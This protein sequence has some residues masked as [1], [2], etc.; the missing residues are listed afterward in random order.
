MSARP[1]LTEEVRHGQLLAS[2]AADEI[3]RLLGCSAPVSFQAGETLMAQGDEGSDMWLLLDGAAEVR[4]D[5]KTLA[6]HKAGQVIGEMS[7]LDPA[8]RA[9]TVV[10]TAKGQAFRLQRDAFLQLLD[11]RD[12]VAIKTLR[13]LTAIAC[14]R[15]GHMNALV[16]EEIMGPQEKGVLKRL[17]RKVTGR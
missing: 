13:A 16:Q 3:Q 4:R 10:A 17:W 5:G 12:D 2:L 6:L 1:T 9:A 14:Q 11:E 8:P 15:L 7:L